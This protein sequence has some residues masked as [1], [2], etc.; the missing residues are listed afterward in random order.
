MSRI[1]YEVS[2]LLLR[3][4]LPTGALRD[5]GL[6]G[7]TH[8][9][10]WLHEH[11][12]K[13]ELYLHCQVRAGGFK[14]LNV[15]TWRVLGDGEL[16]PLVDFDVS[17]MLK[18]YVTSKQVARLGATT[19]VRTALDNI[20]KR[21][22]GQSGYMNIMLHCIEPSDVHEPLHDISNLYLGSGRQARDEGR[23]LDKRERI[24]GNQGGWLTGRKRNDWTAAERRTLR[25][26]NKL[27]KGVT[28]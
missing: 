22:R 27:I 7:C 26:L 14:V 5:V 16:L 3:Q 1:N 6:T 11:M 17:M 4:H 21:L 12:T 2:K 8:Y 20:V 13:P 19:A 24:P 25:L 28:E 18:R 15:L 9:D 23:T 10:I